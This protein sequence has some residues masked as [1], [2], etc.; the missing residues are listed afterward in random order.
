M[1][2]GPDRGTSPAK[3]RIVAQLRETGM[4]EA[5]RARLA[6]SVQ[7]FAKLSAALREMQDGPLAELASD[8]RSQETFGRLQTAVTTFSGQ[9]EKILAGYLGLDKLPSK[10]EP[11]AANDQAKLQVAKWLL[12]VVRSRRE[13]IGTYITTL[14]KENAGRPEVLAKLE[15]LS[16]MS[17]DLEVQ[18]ASVL[19]VYAGPLAKKADAMVKEHVA[20]VETELVAA[21]ELVSRE[22][23]QL[24]DGL[25]ISESSLSQMKSDWPKLQQ[26]LVS[27]MYLTEAEARENFVAELNNFLMN[28]LSGLSSGPQ[29]F[30]VKGRGELL[31]GLS[32]A[33]QAFT[34][35][36]HQQFPLE[37]IPV[38]AQAQMREGRA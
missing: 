2:V 22:A 32:S 19:D 31:S 21:K 8:L 18:M 20:R 34:Q 25:S 37:Q 5:N 7:V 29:Y 11:V 9:L 13:T 4:T 3:G 30:Q 6:Y 1:S 36:C 26:E 24:L 10:A 23:N 16:K 12:G 27:K 33:I 38:V 17:Q 28:K 15:R 14:Q 35:A